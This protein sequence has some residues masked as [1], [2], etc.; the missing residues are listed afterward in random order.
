MIQ[1][2]LPKIEK[3]YGLFDFQDHFVRNGTKKDAVKLK[4]F[5]HSVH[6][7]L[8]NK[9]GEIM[10]C[11]RPP[12]ANRYPNQITSSAGG[13]VEK[14]ESY[15]VAAVRELEEEL[16]IVTSLENVGRFDVVTSKERAI[17]HL[18]IGK[19]HNK[20]LADPK[21]ICNYYFLTPKRIQSDL[22]LH[23]RKYCK[24][25]HKAFALYLKSKS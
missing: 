8:I 19:A 2:H 13:H 21:E 16:G 14:G 22:A 1:K 24:P 12:N 17:H 25:F 11:Q 5:T 6:I 18:F 7:L 9:N 23:P 4:L 10:L 15:K 3:E 20:I